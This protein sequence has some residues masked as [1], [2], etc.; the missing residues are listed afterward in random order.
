M[1]A[2]HLL[3]SIK[4]GGAENV[5]Y[6]YAKVL[7]RLGINSLIVGKKNSESYEKKLSQYASLKYTLKLK[8]IKDRDI[9]F[10]HSNRNLLRLLLVSLFIK[11]KNVRIIYIQHLLYSEKKFQ[12]ISKIINR[13]CT[14]FIQITPIT[15]PLVNKYIHIPSHFIVNFS[16]NNYPKNQWSNLRESVR[17]E[18]GLSENEKV[19]V[20]SAIFKPGKG[21]DFA[22]NL[23][24]AMKENIN[25]R[26]LVLGDGQEADYVRN[27]EYN[28]LIWLGRVNDVE[29][30]LIASDI[31]LFPS[32]FKMEMMPMALIEAINVEKSILA[33]DTPINRFLLNNDVF[34]NLEQMR[35]ALENEVYKNIYN[36]YDDKYAYNKLK[37]LLK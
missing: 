33:L 37:E 6:N 24:R 28:N 19:V 30:Y 14:D 26:F 1:K 23:A 15:T 35:S 8:D 18:L 32:L 9:I 27:Y 12:F 4:A 34:N 22:V 5:A 20:F 10:I 13:V 2:I 17:K 7:Q 21:V 31:Y 36:R 3:D 16:I 29:K 11:R 25:Y